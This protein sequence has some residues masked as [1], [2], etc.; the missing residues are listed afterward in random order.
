MLTGDNAQTVSAIAAQ[1]G[2]E[3]FQA[4]TLPSAKAAL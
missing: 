4:D 1:A 2:I 3:H